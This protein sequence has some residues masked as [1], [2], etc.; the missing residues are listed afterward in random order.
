MPIFNRS[1][2]I[3]GFN[4]DYRSDHDVTKI[5]RIPTI[6]RG[7]YQTSNPT[8]GQFFKCGIGGGRY[9]TTFAKGLL[10]RALQIQ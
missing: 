8:K 6:L 4:S 10:P 9:L 1:Q 5:G 2:S 7:G 3:T